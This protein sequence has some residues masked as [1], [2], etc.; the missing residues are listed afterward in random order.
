MLGFGK[1]VKAQIF[2]YSDIPAQA[3]I[4]EQA[5]FYDAITDG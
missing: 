1:L 3:G 2:R 4:S 5:A